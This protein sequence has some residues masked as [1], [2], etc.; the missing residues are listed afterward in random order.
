MWGREDFARKEMAVTCVVLT[1]VGVPVPPALLT[2]LSPR[3]SPEVLVTEPRPRRARQHPVPQPAPFPSSLSSAPW[4]VR[5][6][7]SGSS[8]NMALAEMPGQGLGA[9]SLADNPL[10]WKEPGRGLQGAVGTGWGARGG[11]GGRRGL[12]LSPGWSGVSWP[13]RRGPHLSLH[14]RLREG[15]TEGA[16]AQW[17][18]CLS[19]EPP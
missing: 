1:C 17:V 13:G 3:P 10:P 4:H 7:G 8:Q 12:A 9:G 15:C 5:R 2:S 16:G 6:P 19:P 18:L 11:A 14:T